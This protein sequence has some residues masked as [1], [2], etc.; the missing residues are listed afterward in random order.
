M[1]APIALDVTLDAGNK[2]S[3]LD[4]PLTQTGALIGTP[5][6]MA[7][8]QYLGSEPDPRTDQFAFC[9]TAWQALTGKRPFEG[10]TLDELRKAMNR[11]VAHLQVKLPRRV[12]AVLARGL[13]PDPDK[14]WGSLDDLIAALDAARGATRRRLGLIAPAFAFAAA[15]VLFFTM[16]RSEPAKKPD[17]PYACQPPEVAFADA[18]TNERRN[19]LEKRVGTAAALAANALDDL[20][21]AWLKSYAETCA[22]PPSQTTFARLGCLLADATTSPRSCGSPIRCRRRRST[23]SICTA[24]CRAS[25]PARATRRSHRRSCPTTASNATRSSRSAR[26]SR[27]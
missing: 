18:W 8:E 11:G 21:A 17:S 6:Y 5:A 16:H 19:A 14:R 12:R 2:D 15:G 10:N 22:A 1:N 25:R 27:R 24:S 3:V 7:P 4:S 13:D 26:R 9:V 23:T 20:R